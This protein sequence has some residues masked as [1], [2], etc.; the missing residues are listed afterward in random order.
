MGVKGEGWAGGRAKEE[1][2]CCLCKVEFGRVIG[3]VAW[4]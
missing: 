3:G 1:V 2:S 4:I